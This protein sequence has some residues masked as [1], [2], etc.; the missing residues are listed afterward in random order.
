MQ[1]FREYHFQF[2]GLNFISSVDTESSFYQR[3]KAMPENLFIEMNLNL[4]SNLLRGDMLYS[5]E[6]IHSELDR[7]NAGG[8]FA[9]IQL[10]ENN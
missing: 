8:S 6:A 3:I 4:L 7:I 2:N 10:G 5:K 9:F 1:N